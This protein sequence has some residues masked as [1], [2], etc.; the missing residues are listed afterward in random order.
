MWKYL[1]ICWSLRAKMKINRS[2]SLSVD[3]GQT[4][5]WPGGGGCVSSQSQAELLSKVMR[6]SPSYDRAMVT[7]MTMT[8]HMKD[9]WVSAS[10]PLQSYVKFQPP[11]RLRG[12][13]N[14]CD[15]HLLPVLRPFAATWVM[16]GLSLLRLKFGPK[17]GERGRGKLVEC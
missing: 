15:G 16:R 14:T 3:H 1:S 9:V 12:H 10:Y 13:S 6:M 2:I 4:F 5:R 8:I 11:W 17:Q 7:T